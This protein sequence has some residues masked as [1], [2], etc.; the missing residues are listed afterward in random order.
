MGLLEM[1]GH[2]AKAL[3]LHLFRHI[4]RGVFRLET[5]VLDPLFHRLFLA[6]DFHAGLELI[7]RHPREAFL[8][9]GYQLFLVI[10][11]IR[12]AKNHAAHTALRDE[13]VGAFR[14]IGRRL[15]RGIEGV[16]MFLQQVRGGVIGVQP[17]RTV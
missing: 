2:L 12:R 10:V 3:K 13:S 5:L 17:Q 1:F 6:H 4:Q 14:R 16:E 15:L 8:V 11:I 9:Q 7:E